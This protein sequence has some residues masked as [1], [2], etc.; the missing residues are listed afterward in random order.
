LCQEG[1]WGSGSWSEN[2]IALLVSYDGTSFEGFTEPGTKR[3]VARWIRTSLQKI[4][5]HEELVLRAASRTDKGVHA[6][7]QVVCYRPKELPYGGDLDRLKFALNRMLPGDV[8]VK[9]V[10]MSPYSDFHPSVDAIGKQYTYK[11]DTSQIQDPMQRLYSWHYPTRSFGC[12]NIDI[13]LMKEG[14][15]LLL[16]QNNFKAF[17][18]SFRGSE[19]GK[20]GTIDTLCTLAALD[21]FCSTELKSPMVNF[22]FQG[23]RFLYKMIRNMV[24]SLVLVG[25]KELSLTDIKGSLVNGFFESNNSNPKLCAPPHG[26]TLDYVKYKQEIFQHSN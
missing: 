19:R 6:S 9:A 24:G 10:A 13:N 2:N 8:R 17:M 5:S 1:T 3:S 7:G 11:I 22:V 18:G 21:I 15:K 20:D 26:L 14:A 25:R 16:G 4:H 12:R 23:D